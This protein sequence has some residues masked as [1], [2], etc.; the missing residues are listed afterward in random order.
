MKNTTS[1]LLA[2]TLL[3]LTVVSQSAMAMSQ[4]P[5]GFESV[6]PGNNVSSVVFDN[7]ASLALTSSSEGASG[8]ESFLPGYQ[9]QGSAAL[10][11]VSYMS[12]EATG[13]II[14]AYDTTK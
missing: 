3:T 2:A 13:N 6:L 7:S 8:Y 10:M 11:K 1:K 12:Q 5:S 9:D 14:D 4:G